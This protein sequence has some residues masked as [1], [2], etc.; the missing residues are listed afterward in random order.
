[1]AA[2]AIRLCII[3]DPASVVVWIP[4]GTSRYSHASRAFQA[5]LILQSER[6]PNTF[7]AILQVSDD[8]AGWISEGTSSQNLCSYAA[9]W[10]RSNGRGAYNFNSNS[11][12]SKRDVCAHSAHPPTPP[13]LISPQRP[14]E[15]VSD[16]HRDRWFFGTTR[17]NP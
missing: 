9:G 11:L 7:R 5:R 16:R 6:L 12:T 8:S 17:Q 10:P 15:T 14:S 2:A 13:H 3:C 1:M 4:V